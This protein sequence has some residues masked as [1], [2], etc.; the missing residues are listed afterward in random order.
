MNSISPKKIELFL[1]FAAVYI[2][3]GSTYLGIKFA[4]VS[5]PPFLMAG[6]RF[7]VSSII[8]YVIA[9]FQGENKIESAHWKDSFIIGAFLLL[10]GN[11]G[12]VWAEQYVPSGLT[13]LL[14]A[15]VPIWIVIF[16]WI[17]PHGSKPTKKVATG[18]ILGFIGV[19]FLISPAKLMQSDGVNPLGALALLISTISWA[20]GSVYSKGAVLAKSKLLTISMEMFSGGILLLLLSCF[21]NEWSHFTISAISLKAFLAWG[22]LIVFGSIIGFSSYIWLLDAAGPSRASTYAYINPV[23]AVFLGWALAGEELN[24]R[25]VFSMIVIVLAVVFIISKKNFKDYFKFLSKA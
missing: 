24:L 4:I 3:W 18:I 25:I 22:Y 7:I 5:F 8:L 1:A 20:I 21:F 16:H 17:S 13:A 23:I 11:G 14:V 19:A 15:T 6:S 9:K 12:V 2:I 10:G